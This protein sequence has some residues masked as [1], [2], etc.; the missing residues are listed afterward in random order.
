LTHFDTCNS[1]SN[2]R[3][4]ATTQVI[5]AYEKRGYATTQVTNAEEN[6]AEKS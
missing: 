6:A 4:Y 5:N 3:G 2:E 1:K